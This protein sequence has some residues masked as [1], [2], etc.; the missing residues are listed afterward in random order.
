MS[1]NLLNL[2]VTS[3]VG[4]ASLAIIVFMVAMA[5]YLLYHVRKLMKAKPGKQGWD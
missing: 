2:L 5:G 4:L 3:D 1:M